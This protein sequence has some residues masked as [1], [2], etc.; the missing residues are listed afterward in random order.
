MH[1]I[2]QHFN[3]FRWTKELLV[4]CQMLTFRRPAHGQ[5]SKGKNIEKYGNFGPEV[6]RYNFDKK[7]IPDGSIFVQKWSKKLPGSRSSVLT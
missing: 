1:N 4:L 6:Q 3:P 2:C 5:P 7:S